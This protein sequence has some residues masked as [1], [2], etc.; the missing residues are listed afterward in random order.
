MNAIARLFDE[1]TINVKA[2]ARKNGIAPT[3]LYSI[4]N[5]KVNAEAIGI[6]NWMKISHGLNMTADELYDY[7]FVRLDDDAE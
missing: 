4:I 2:F 5:G 6:S 1:R 3:T 7:V